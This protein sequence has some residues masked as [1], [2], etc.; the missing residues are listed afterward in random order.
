MVVPA[1]RFV[2][3]ACSIPA[4]CSQLPYFYTTFSS[5][6]ADDE[7]SHQIGPFLMQWEDD[8]DDSK[9]SSKWVKEAAAESQRNAAAEAAGTPA[10]PNVGDCV[11]VRDAGDGD[12]CP[13]VVDR[14]ESLADNAAGFQVFVRKY[15]SDDAFIWDDW[16]W[17]PKKM[18]RSSRYDLSHYDLKT[19][20]C[21]VERNF[22]VEG[23]LES[24]IRIVNDLGIRPLPIGTQVEQKIDG[25][26]ECLGKVDTVHF[27]FEDESWKSPMPDTCI[28]LR[29]MDYS[30][31]SKT[32][33]SLVLYSFNMNESHL[34]AVGDETAKLKDWETFLQKV[35]H[36]LKTMFLS[37][38]QQKELRQQ[39]IRGLLGENEESYFD[40]AW[41]L[42]NPLLP[43]SVFN[44]I[45]PTALGTDTEAAGK[46]V[47]IT[48][49]LPPELLRPTRAEGRHVWEKMRRQH[50]SSAENG[51]VAFETDKSVIRE[52]FDQADAD[53][54]GTLDLDE[55][56]ELCKIL[57]SDLQPHEL[58]A[59]LDED[60]DGSVTFEEFR[61]WWMALLPPR[62]EKI[63]VHSAPGKNFIT[64]KEVRAALNARLLELSEKRDF[65]LVARNANATPIQGWIFAHDIVKMPVPTESLVLID[66]HSGQSLPDSAVL[67]RHKTRNEQ[68]VRDAFN[69]ADQDKNGSLDYHEV[70]VL[71][72]SL[73]TEMTT[74]ELEAEMDADHDGT[75]SF[76][77]FETWWYKTA[78]VEV[79]V[80]LKGSFLL[81]HL[82][83]LDWQDAAVRDMAEKLHDQRHEANPN[84]MLEIGVNQG[85]RPVMETRLVEWWRIK[86]GLE[87]IRPPAFAVQLDAQEIAQQK[88]FVQGIAESGIVEQIPDF[89]PLVLTV[90]ETVYS[91]KI[92]DPEAT[93]AIALLLEGKK[94]KAALLAAGVLAAEGEA[95]TVP[96]V[97]VTAVALGSANAPEIKISVKARARYKSNPHTYG[98]KRMWVMAGESVVLDREVVLDPADEILP[99]R[100]YSFY[101]SATNLQLKG[102]TLCLSDGKTPIQVQQRW[103]QSIIEFPSE[104]LLPGEVRFQP[105]VKGYQ[106]PKEVSVLSLNGVF[107]KS[108]QEQKIYLNPPPKNDEYRISL[109][110]ASKPRDLA[111][112]MASSMGEICNWRWMR[113][114]KDFD[115]N[116]GEVITFE[117]ESG[118]KYVF[119]VLNFSGE[120]EISKS[121]AT[122]RIT[123]ASIDA[124]ISVPRLYSS[125]SCPKYW[126]AFGIDEKGHVVHF[127]SSSDRNGFLVD[128]NPGKMWSE[129]ETATEK[130]TLDSI[131]GFTHGDYEDDI[132]DGGAGELY[133]KHLNKM[134]E[135]ARQSK[136]HAKITRQIARMD[137]HTLASSCPVTTASS[138]PSSSMP[139][140]QAPAGLLGDAATNPYGA[141]FDILPPEE[142]ENHP[143]AAAMVPEV[144]SNAM[145]SLIPGAKTKNDVQAADFRRRNKELLLAEA[146]YA[147]ED[148]TTQDALLDS[149]GSKDI[150]LLLK[151]FF[152]DFKIHGA[153]GAL[154][155]PMP[156]RKKATDSAEERDIEMSS[157][158]DDDKEE[159]EK[160]CGEVAMSESAE[161]E[162]EHRAR[163]KE[164]ASVILPALKNHVADSVPSILDLAKALDIED[165]RAEV[166]EVCDTMSFDELINVLAHPFQ[167]IPQIIVVRKIRNFVDQKAACVVCNLLSQAVPDKLIEISKQLQS[168]GEE[169]GGEEEAEKEDA[170]VEKATEV[171]EIMGVD[172]DEE[173]ED[174]SNSSLFEI[175]DTDQEN[176]T[177]AFHAIRNEDIIRCLAEPRHAFECIIGKFPTLLLYG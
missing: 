75:I 154:A 108:V 42:G 163:L 119:Y 150:G 131:A 134:K 39:G 26:W 148:K 176:L 43:P 83:D 37:K 24:D 118:V 81:M 175:D 91:L 82:L 144:V 167:I 29:L 99:A 104:K 41:Q 162:D 64:Y 168:E 159:E 2:S 62:Y 128:E 8:G 102:V 122:L 124:A 31:R 3:F 47:E 155:C 130:A 58:Q 166:R 76:E 96:G 125:K 152:G 73:G 40:G 114:K 111:M 33:D 116:G 48:V 79:R 90:D 137:A 12:W 92:T 103:N 11:E 68:S 151:S 101:D 71:C 153:R 93:L 49:E 165:C 21:S 105:K 164:L 17:P 4:A 98:P 25:N 145:L 34:W 117:R 142:V 70:A 77:K 9:E 16:R 136:L 110:W 22:D 56:T 156:A 135:R 100:Q 172:G 57:G 121:E 1:Q 171:L 36:N 147:C 15:S 149:I 14:V 67:K 7:P 66:K 61:A 161:H 72:E 86:L 170:G 65:E 88:V 45:S 129:A 54:S 95:Q 20:N 69:E 60:G 35:I 146:T 59:D 5:M 28:D 94:G 46:V 19:H 74:D 63:K 115:I 139:A 143:G 52:A 50:I 120:S 55:I 160:E 51:E 97:I 138:I 44:T 174:E 132:D 27:H 18:A 141:V 78:D 127:G 107:K 112:H 113:N 30:E 109:R 85:L 173:D 38:E 133:G 80:D 87:S 169:E 126:R 53:N 157:S 158:P 177:E 84:I 89:G 32:G 10:K 123:A 140:L 13:G 23:R 106:T 6:P